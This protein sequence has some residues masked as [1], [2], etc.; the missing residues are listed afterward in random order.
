MPGIATLRRIAARTATVEPTYSTGP[1]SPTRLAT[2]SVNSTTWNSSPA[3]ASAD[4][5]IRK[6][7]SPE[8]RPPSSRPATI[9]RATA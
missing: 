6:V 5:R 3:S 8:N 7:Q 2:R 9:P 4:Q 1:A